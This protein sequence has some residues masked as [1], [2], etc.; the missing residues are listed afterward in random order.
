[1][2]WKYVREEI[3]HFPSTPKIGDTRARVVFAFFP[4]WAEDGFVYWLERVRI[5]EVY[6]ETS[7]GTPGDLVTTVEWDEDVCIGPSRYPR[8]TR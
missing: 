2:R 1:M 3:K 8:G 5:K 6:R 7:F 4:R